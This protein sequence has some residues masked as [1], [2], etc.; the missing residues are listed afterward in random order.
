MERRKFI[1]NTLLTAG[2]II[3]APYILPSGRLF[4]GTGT[5]RVNH[6]VLAL[7]AGGVRNLESVHQNDGN[8]MPYML[9][10]NNP[11]KSDIRGGVKDL[12]AFDLGLGYNMQSRGTLFKEF[13]YKEGPT[14]HFNGHTVAI[15][16][17]YTN[18]GLNLRSHP[19]SPTIFELYRKHNGADTSALNSWWVAD[20][21]GSYPFLEY[22]E[23]PD[24]GPLYGANYIAP[25]SLVSNGFAALGN[26]INF[27]TSQ[28][29]NIARI[30]NFVNGAFGKSAADVGF[31]NDPANRKK[32]KDFYFELINKTSSNQYTYPLPQNLMNGDMRTMFY[33]TEV[34]KKFQPELMCVNI[35]NVD[36]GHSDFTG[37]ANNM[38]R[39]D[40]AIAH[41]WKTIQ[42][43]P[44]MKDDT[45]MIVVPE[46]GRNKEANNIRDAYGRYALDHT[47]DDTSRE[48]FCL[49]IG[50]Q[51]KEVVKYNNTISQVM[52]E[53]IDVV[54]T[55]A[56][57]LGFMPDIP[58]GLLPGRVLKEA[59]V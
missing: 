20:Q 38:H 2:G 55:I 49:M 25:K 57:I 28:E 5:R 47:S 31:T 35:T 23:H 39:A 58:G 15:T 45:V 50:P 59:F 18:T 21:L 13:R 7:Y 11:I 19:Q 37:Y 41:L 34:L 12:S 10:G 46:H 48:L 42:E 22:S 17:N 36:I 26:P 30:H 8:L 52:G 56:D 16:G 4:A 40:Y 14:G 27:N 51:N 29:E 6:V 53:S 33:A 3:A 9:S 43:T 54:P 32:V 24:Y 1:K 44:G